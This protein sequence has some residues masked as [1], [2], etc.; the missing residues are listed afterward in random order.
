MPP[1]A[2]TVSNTSIPQFA[3]PYPVDGSDY[4]CE[5]ALMITYHSSLDCVRRFVPDMLE[6]AD[7]PEVTIMFLQ[8]TM[9]SFGPY[10]EYVHSVKVKYNGDEYDYFLLLILDNDSPIACGR[11]QWGFPKKA[12]KVSL[13]LKETSCVVRSCVERPVGQKIVEVGFQPERRLDLKGETMQRTMQ[14]LNLR[15]F[16]LSCR[17]RGSSP[18]SR[19]WFLLTLVFRQ[20]RFGRA[21]G[22]FV[23]RSHRR[24]TRCMSLRF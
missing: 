18:P 8:H 7:E 19:N 11:E 16:P 10:T 17:G 24:W 6:L 20:A 3:A 23:F 15:S 5:A 2:L 12:G 14:G 9:T 21:W 4:T 1:G 13:A 22:P